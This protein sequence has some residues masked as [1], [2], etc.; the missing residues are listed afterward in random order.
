MKGNLD[1]FEAL[2]VT[3]SER[4]SKCD[5][6]RHQK[7][8]PETGYCD[9]CYRKMD[10]SPPNNSMEKPDETREIRARIAYQKVIDFIKGFDKIEKELNISSPLSY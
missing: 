2:C 5:S 4:Y 9:F 7:P 10:Y 6:E 1:D 3:L 8:N